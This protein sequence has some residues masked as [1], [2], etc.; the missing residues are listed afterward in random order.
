MTGPLASGSDRYI[1]MTRR[2]DDQS[3]GGEDME[4]AMAATVFRDL[5]AAGHIPE[6]ARLA[7]APPAS[8]AGL[9][10]TSYEA[11][12]V[13]LIRDRDDDGR[14]D[15]DMGRLRSAGIISGDVPDENELERTLS[16]GPRDQLSDAFINRQARNSELN[17][18]NVAPNA[19]GRRIQDYSR[20]MELEGSQDRTQRDFVAGIP[21][22]ATTTQAAGRVAGEAVAGAQVLLRQGDQHHAQ[23]LLAD[24]GAALM[25]AGQ[26]DAAARVYRELTEPPYAATRVNLMQDTVDRAHREMRDYEPGDDIRL[27]RGGSSNTIDISDF[28]S[29]YGELANH[30]LRQIETHDR[31]EAALGRQIDPRD[32]DDARAYFQSYAQGRSADEV[33]TEYQG[34]LESFYSHTGHGVEW[35][36]AIPGNDRPAQM[37]ALLRNQPHDA[38]G[39]TLVDCEGY[40]YMTDRILGGLTDD[41]GDR[42]FDVLYASR[43]G[44]IITTVFD[45]T[46]AQG[47]SVDNS[48]TEMLEGD[49]TTDAGRLNAVAQSIAGEYYNVVGVSRTSEGSSA[50]RSEDG[51]PAVGAYIYNGREVLGT[52]TPE[53]QQGFAEWRGR[54]LS[55]SVSE[56]L[57]ALDRGD[58][59][60]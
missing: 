59:R 37:T 11:R 57:A 47:F 45:R 4:V 35:N 18:Y 10:G 50:T 42:R 1:E 3:D 17:S 54:R 46:A 9:R 43:P 51:A 13:E 55:G 21:D 5:Q 38:S 60:P 16:N 39:R 27:E 44:H 56:Y 58:V 23:E 28:R 40:S 12:L 7:D 48:D 25:D 19:R 29:T 52:V 36:D 22:R 41:N 6:S 14:L 24:S 26:R 53:L 20:G 31:M 33:R 34:Y 30:R 15:L 49:L 32:M 8:G 2:F